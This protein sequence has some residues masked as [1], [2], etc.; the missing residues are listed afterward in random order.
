MGD[1]EKRRKMF[2]PGAWNG[3]NFR[4]GIAGQIIQ[5]TLKAGV[6]LPIWDRHTRM[7]GNDADAEGWV[8]HPSLSATQTELFGEPG[9]Y[10]NKLNAISDKRPYFSPEFTAAG[11]KTREEAEGDLGALRIGGFAAVNRAQ[12]L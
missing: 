6:D 12:L 4:A 10:S 5:N 9:E 1:R 7:D 11:I 8:R 2:W 3:F